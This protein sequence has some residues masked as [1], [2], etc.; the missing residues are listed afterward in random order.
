MKSLLLITHEYPLNK[1]D[2][3][4]I[5]SEMQYLSEKFE[6]IY[7]FCLNTYHKNDDLLSVPKNVYVNF[8]VSNNRKIKK[9]IL[10]LSLV[11]TPIFYQEL[12]LLV[13]KKKLSIKTVYSMIVFLFFAIS[14]QV[15]IKRL[16]KANKDISL[17]YTYWYV[18]ETLS[19][20]LLKGLF[21]NIPCVTR[22][23]GYD[24]YKF[25]N[26]LGYQPFKSLMDKKIDKIFFASHHGYTYYLNEFAKCGLGKYMLARLG[27]FNKYY[28]D[29]KSNKGMDAFYI[30]S[31]SYI[32]SLK[33]IHLI[34]KAM[35]KIEECRI[36]WVHIGDGSDANIIKSIA[37]KVLGNKNNVSYEFKGFLGNEQ[38]M[39][40]YSEN[41]IDCF[42]S[43][44]ESEGLPV[45]MMEAISFGIPV[46]A[47]NVGGVSELV[48]DTG[49]LLSS[50]GNVSEVSKAIIDFYNLSENKKI[51]MR[52]AARSFWESNFNAEIN[53]AKFSEELLLVA[54]KVS[55]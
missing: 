7:I 4:F 46:I 45:S 33:R 5:E 3:S 28:V 22:T 24:L 51:T 41:Y 11:F 21:N 8:H 1:G 55:I 15:P 37:D 49:I 39:K 14:L 54:N 40:F 12:I 30:C 26:T 32:V 42:I 38:V 16:L 29:I 50:D 17:I 25:R 10:L 20:L 48:K 53:H 36:H 31:C 52:R 19:V 27:I 34:I 23:H 13:R 18:Q 47:T 44:S 35:G 2:A 9:I 6:K 43:T